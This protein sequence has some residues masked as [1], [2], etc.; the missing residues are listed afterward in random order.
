MGQTVN[1]EQL[2]LTLRQDTRECNTLGKGDQSVTAPM[3][4][5]DVGP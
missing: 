2:Y 3:Q 5:D 1:E 4:Q